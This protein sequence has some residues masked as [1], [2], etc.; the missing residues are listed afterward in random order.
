MNIIKYPIA[1]EKSI[2]MIE[3]EN[4]LMFAVDID[5]T[6]LQ[7]KQEIEKQFNAKVKSVNTTRMN[8]IKKATVTFAKETP[9]MDVATAMGLI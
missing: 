3:T 6:K 2:R 4:K 5:A 7:I 9:A 8:A 1:S